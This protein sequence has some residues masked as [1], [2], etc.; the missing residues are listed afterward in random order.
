MRKKF[1]WVGL[2]F[3][4]IASMLAASL[5]A[6]CSKSSTTTTAAQVTTTTVQ[7]TTPAVA[8]PVTGGTLTVST[9]W[10][11]EEPSGFDDLTQRIW[12]GSVWINPFTEWLCRGDVTTYGPRGS[13]AYGFQT[14]EAIP[15]QYLTG[16]L[17]SKWEISASP[18][19]MKF[20][21][22]QGVMFT[23]NAKIGMAARE[24]TSADV[25]YSLKRTIGTPGPGSYLGM[26]SD[27][28]AFDRY[29]VIVSL[30]QYEAN[31]FFIFGGGMAMG[32][33]QPK[34]M[35]DANATAA[36][37]KNSTG[38]GPFIL[39]DY[40]AGVGATYSKNPNYWG[41]TTI[42]GKEY[43]LPFIDKL[44]YPVIAD[45]STRLANLRTGTIDWW[46]GVKFQYADNLKTTASGMKADQFLY[47]KI[48]L[49]R[50]NRQKSAT[51]K[52]V[53]VRRAIMIGLNLKDISMLLY[54]G[55]DIAS[56]PIGPQVPGYTPLDKLPA[57][58]QELFTYDPVKA[59]QMLKDAGVAGMSLEIDTDAADTDL[60]NACYSYWNL[61]GIKVTI[62]VL[63]A[64]AGTAA[65][66]QV[67]YPD[68]LYTNYT[69][70]NP[71]VSMHLV[72]GDVLA[73]NY[74][75]TE[76]FQA[77]YTTIATEMDAAKRVGEETTLALAMLADV[78]M[79]PFAQPYKLNCYWPWMKNYYGELDAGYYNQMPMIKTMWIDQTVKTSMGH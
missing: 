2:S 30:K 52:D 34:E 48:D 5:L 49:W 21:L 75:V 78:G 32:A 44:F 64:T 56:W 19:Q 18:L 61:I 8:P 46:P 36:D 3:L 29:T 27:V 74:L 54:G 53:N 79:I 12:S 72:A 45:E 13:N 57:S 16:E 15:E 63:D 55:G 41:K 26:I 69:V 66:D 37:W 23:A 31:W 71:L 65:R 17:A 24:L 40:T 58:T 4:L 38:T 43:Q 14:W 28:T 59:K 50:I 68:M 76:P 39:T 25:V 70:V 42:G 73:T 51:L 10:G 9:Q 6:S 22:R 1:L 47:G 35:A 77:M 60:A 7:T 20:T 62:K 11:G 67:T 33:I